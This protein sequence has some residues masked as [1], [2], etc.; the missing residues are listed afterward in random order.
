MQYVAHFITQYIRAQVLL[1]I[2]RDLM[3]LFSITMTLSQMFSHFQTLAECTKG[4]D[5]TTWNGYQI[6]NNRARALCYATQHQQFRRMT[7]VTVNQ[8]MSQAHGQLEY[9]QQLQV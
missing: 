7:E 3:Q 4:M 8:L 1:V 9:L 2:K 5:G 6:V